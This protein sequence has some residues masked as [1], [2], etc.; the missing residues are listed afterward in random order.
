MKQ[1]QMNLGID[2]ASVVDS[3]F[4]GSVDTTDRRNIMTSQWIMQTDTVVEETFDEM[5]EQGY[6]SYHEEDFYVQAS[7]PAPPTKNTFSP[8][9]VQQVVESAPA[10]APAKQTSR[11]SRVTQV[12]KNT[13]T[14]RIGPR[15]PKPPP[16]N[17]QLIRKTKVSR[18]ALEALGMEYSETGIYVRLPQ[19]IDAATLQRLR[20]TSERLG[21]MNSKFWWSDPPPAPSIV[22]RPKPNPPPFFPM[23]PPV[24]QQVP[25]QPNPIAYPS[26]MQTN[27]GRAAQ[28]L[29]KTIVSRAAL[30]QM[31]I[32][33]SE[34]AS[35]VL[36]PYKLEGETVQRLKDLS[37][38]LD[39]N[40]RFWWD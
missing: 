36:L 7:A 21:G 28:M 6:E 4:G 26:N 19:R 9:Y 1:I 31:G 11:W 13:N 34:D 35:Y 3:D 38:R 18:H 25:P 5:Q 17:S 16:D 24:Y 40:S 22:T 23:P 29:R 14:T 8:P 33:Y 32:A 39:G 37:R 20:A 27:G 12:F 10:P 15:T 30:Q 2:N